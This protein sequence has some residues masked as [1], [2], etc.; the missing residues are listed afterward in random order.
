MLLNSDLQTMIILNISFYSAK[1]RLDGQCKQIESTSQPE[2]CQLGREREWFERLGCLSLSLSP[3][4]QTD[5][6]AYRAAYGL[7]TLSVISLW[8]NHVTVMTI[9]ILF[10]LSYMYNN[11]AHIQLINTP[12]IYVTLYVSVQLP[13][14][15]Y[16]LNHREEFYCYKVNIFYNLTNRIDSV[17]FFQFAF[18]FVHQLYQHWLKKVDYYFLYFYMDKILFYFVDFNPL[19]RLE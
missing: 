10:Y 9:I 3:S 16:D 19:K 15:K 1:K 7:S 17:I 6:A 5:V 12:W 4:F 8:C 18:L 11:V 13:I 2:T 14:R